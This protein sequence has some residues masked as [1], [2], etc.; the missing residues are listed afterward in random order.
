MV[1]NQARH[2]S[3]A[4]EMNQERL[5]LKT[6]N[7]LLKQKV[8][9]EGEATVVLSTMPRLAEIKDRTLNKLKMG[10]QSAAGKAID[11][12]I[13]ELKHSSGSSMQPSM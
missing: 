7:W 12:F 5:E 10:R 11:A 4:D 1:E 13:R 9:I 6:E 2:L 8:E 3:V